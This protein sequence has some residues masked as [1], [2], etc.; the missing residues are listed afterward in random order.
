MCSL[1]SMATSMVAEDSRGE[2]AS[3]EKGTGGGGGG[4]FFRCWSSGRMGG[5]GGGICSTCGADGRRC[6]AFSIVS[7]ML[8]V[9]CG[10]VPDT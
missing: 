1:L 10:D 8:T 2:V 6:M 9:T 5:G 3:D 4:V 7:S